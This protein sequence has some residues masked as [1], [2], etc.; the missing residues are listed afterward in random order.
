V[1][2]CRWKDK[3]RHPSDT[4]ISE[5][6]SS[7]KAHLAQGSPRDAVVYFDAAVSREISC[8]TLEDSDIVG[9]VAGDGGVEVYHGI[10]G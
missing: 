3:L 5:L 2:F 6:I 10:S 8:A 4:P 9:W 7:A 1:S